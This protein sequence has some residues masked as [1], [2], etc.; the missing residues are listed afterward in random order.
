L[1]K[2]LL[3]TYQSKRLGRTKGGT[4]AVMKHK[5]FSGLDWEALLAKSLPVPIYPN[6]KN[7]ED[8]SNFEKYTDAPDG[9]KKCN[10]NPDF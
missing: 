5:W 7:C 10:W 6:V 1:I 9:A 3:R 8:M 2:K 4:G